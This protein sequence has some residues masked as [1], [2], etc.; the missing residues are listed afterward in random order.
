MCGWVGGGVWVGMWVRG[1][2]SCCRRVRVI[3]AHLRAWHGGA[4]VRACAFA[5]VLPAQ[6]MCC[7]ALTHRLPAHARARVQIMYGRE[8]GADTLVEQMVRDQ[9]RKHGPGYLEI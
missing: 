3:Q 9:V 4:C 5:H 6:P 1:G 8:E 2:R 7:C